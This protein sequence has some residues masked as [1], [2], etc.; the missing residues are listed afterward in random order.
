[1]PTVTPTIV[2]KS[3]HT[4]RSPTQLGDDKPTTPTRLAPPSTPTH[5]LITDV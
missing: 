2:S 4:P 3:A 1:M 5:A